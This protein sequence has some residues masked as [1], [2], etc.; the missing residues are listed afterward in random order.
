MTNIITLAADALL[1]T[2]TG[3]IVS[4]VLPEENSQDF[5]GMSNAEIAE[6]LFDE[7]Q[8]GRS[9]IGKAIVPQTFTTADDM[10]EAFKLADAELKIDAVKGA[11]SN[12]AVIIGLSKV[13]SI[14]SQRGKNHTEMR[15]QAG[16]PTWEEYYKTFCRDNAYAKSL[17][18]TQRDLK[19]L[20]GITPPPPPEP[21]PLLTGAEKR[22]LVDVGILAYEVVDAMT[23]GVNIDDTI[24]VMQ[25]A[26]PSRD[27]L[28][29]LK[30]N[31]SRLTTDAKI[32]IP[33]DHPKQLHKTNM[34]LDFDDRL[35]A[36]IVT[37][38]TDVSQQ[39]QGHLGI[40]VRG[41]LRKLTV[42][43]TP[44]TPANDKRAATTITPQQTYDAITCWPHPLDS[45]KPAEAAA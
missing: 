8:A 34:Y 18:Q 24:K 19:V 38:L 6:V 40:K 4:P 9:T 39:L 23:A 37:V 26:L 43:E 5:T 42:G 33:P 10:K 13:Q 44:K 1:P 41:L 20:S 35:K 45:A 11:Q 31:P 3:D 27:K 32:P 36:E 16:L 30:D 15:K 7:V 22:K 21:N 2:E 29:S 14:L 28:Y 17:R 12:Y 25:R